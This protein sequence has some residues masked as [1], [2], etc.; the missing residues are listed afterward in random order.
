M[1]KKYYAD[2]LLFSPGEVDIQLRLNDIDRLMGSPLFRRLAPNRKI[3]RTPR[4]GP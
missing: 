4:S 2:A 3:T 1:A